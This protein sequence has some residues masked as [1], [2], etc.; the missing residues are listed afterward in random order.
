MENLWPQNLTV[1]QRKAPVTILREQ[2]SL[3][4]EATQNIVKA[5]VISKGGSD[6]MFLY[7]FLI[8]A[9]TFDNYHYK[10]F[11]IR[12]GIDLYPV[13][14]SLDEA[15]AAEL[16]IGSEKEMLAG[17]EAEFIEILKRIFH[18]KRT[19]SIVQ[20]IVAQSTAL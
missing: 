18:S 14:I 5:N 10:L 1:T 7:I 4:G 6:T 16:D 13:T 12:H 20:A 17:S 2:A 19:V 8:V 9:P 11:T 3:L 15:I